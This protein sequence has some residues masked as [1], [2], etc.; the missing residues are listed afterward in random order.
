MR[1]SA[2]VLAAGKSERMGVNKLLLRIAG[3]TLLDLILEALEA[4]SL[5]EVYVVL[6]H[7]PEELRPIIKRHDVMEVLNPNYEA[8]MLSSFKAGLRRVSAEA[9][10]LILGDQLLEPALLVRMASV[11]EGDPQA[12][13]VS[14]THMGRRGHPV[15]FRRT[16]FG[17]ILNLGDGE[18][19]RD[20]IERHS[21][22]H[23][24]VEGGPLC[25]L[26]IDTPEDFERARR[27]YEALS[28]SP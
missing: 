16:I 23:R 13:I 20:L 25:I 21:S 22:A 26:D 15:L 9:A 6:G 4:S 27:L 17:E 8:G 1:L 10:F 7:K 12:L 24:L 19:L 28:S 11:M 2:V 14:P 5:Q 3:K 18:T